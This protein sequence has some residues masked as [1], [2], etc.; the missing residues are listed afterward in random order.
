MSEKSKNTAVATVGQFSLDQIPNLLTQINEKIKSLEGDSEETS[1]MSGPIDMFGEL[2]NINE[3]IKLMEVYNYVT[4]KM[5]GVE[6]VAP[7]F[8]EAAPTV[9]VPTMKIAGA[10]L[11]ILQKAIL[12]R[13]K[14]VT[15]AEVLNGLKKTKT[16]LEECLSEEDKKVA[17]LQ[18]AGEALAS[19]L[20][21]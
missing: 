13:Y 3:P 10:T 18:N 14:A 1:V 17:K 6:A 4:K 15:L 12:S 11:P 20:G 8:K 21:A 7:I 5:E 16:I 9:K 19:L 2:K